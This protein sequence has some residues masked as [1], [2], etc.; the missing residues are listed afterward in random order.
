VATAAV[1]SDGVSRG[2]F[3]ALRLGIGRPGTLVP[4]R[5]AA[6]GGH[7]LWVRPRSGDHD[8]IT[9]DCVH[10]FADPP[11]ELAGRQ[12]STIVELGT[13]IG[14]GLCLLAHRHAAA[15]LLGVEA[16]PGSAALAQRNV[17]PWADRV[18][19]L[20]SAVWPRAGHVVLD[21]GS[22]K[23]S[24][25]TVREAD[26]GEHAELKVWARTVEEILE[27][28]RPGRPVDY[29]YMDIEGTHHRLLHGDAPWLQRVRAIKV[30]GHAGTD[31]SDADCAGD[32]ARQG[33]E[34][35]VEPYE[36]VG[37]AVG[38]RP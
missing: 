33:F 13:N 12:L 29:L 2:R 8:L 22:G 3:L 5:V 6:L 20:H 10:G 4:L 30:A 28:F 11:A 9:E 37:W 34:A 21:Q 14:V 7:P 35:R 38:V 24:G 32:L 17:R 15:H 26:G 19:V 16:H 18:Q 27:D 31:Y 23:H 25:F 1:L 36:P